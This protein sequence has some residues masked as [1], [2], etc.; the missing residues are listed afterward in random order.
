MMTEY[1]RCGDSS[2][3]MSMT[4][5][6]GTNREASLD[7][8]THSAE[9][10][11]KLGIRLGELA[12]AGDVLLLVGT[13]GAGKTCLTQGIAQ[14]LGIDEHVVSPT[15]ML[16][17]EYQGRLPLYHIDFYRLERIEEVASLGLDDYLYGNGV[18]VVEWA[19]KGFAALPSEHLLVEMEHLAPSKR[20]LTFLP[21]GSRYVEM[22][23]KL[24]MTT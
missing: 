15:F 6:F 14:G 3:V 9:R 23:S 18:C 5:S 8:V 1:N 17:R 10:T 19:E 20:K 12:E 21:K 24:H 7:M 4:D 16:R 22:L 13:L 11:R 2:G